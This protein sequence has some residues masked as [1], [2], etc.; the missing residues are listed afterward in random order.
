MRLVIA[1]AGPLHY[2][3]LIAEI[4]LLPQMFG[5]VL[6]PE[7]VRTELTRPR[8]PAAVR[9]WLLSDPNWLEQR[10]NPPDRVLPPSKLGKGERAAITLAKAVGAA[11]ILID[12]RAGV[13]TA[14]AQDLEATGTLGV[15][16]LAAKRRLV[17]LPAVLARLKATNFRC[18]AELLETLLARHGG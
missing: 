8:T 4:E 16:A 15:L 3:V 18:R 12:D 1:D 10:A 13:A 17:D 2:L 9:E 7:I 14:R 6:I 11:L 5:K